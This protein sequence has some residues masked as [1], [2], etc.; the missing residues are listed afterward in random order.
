MINI[1]PDE[2]LKPFFTKC[3]FIETLFNYSDHS[4]SRDSKYHDIND[5]NKNKNQSLATLHLNIASVSKQFEDLQNFLFLLKHS[6]DIT[7]IS[8]L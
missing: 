6:F 1:F 5:F 7:G 8:E 2:N 3:N 4:V